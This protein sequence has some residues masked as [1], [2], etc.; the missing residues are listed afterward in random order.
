K[1]KEVPQLCLRGE[2]VSV[3]RPVGELKGFELVELNPKESKII[4]FTLSHAELGFYD[5]NGKYIVEPGTFS[6]FVG[7][8]SDA[9][10]TSKFEL[11]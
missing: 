1:G 2:F 3:T 6:V 5:N 10:L 7:G 4:T 9:T 11:K 8:S